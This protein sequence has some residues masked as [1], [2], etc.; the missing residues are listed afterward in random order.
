MPEGRHLGRVFVASSPLENVA[1]AL[2]RTMGM[3][4]AQGIQGQQAGLID[5]EQALRAPYLQ[6]L[7]KRY[8]EDEDFRRQVW[9]HLRGGQAQQYR[10]G[11]FDVPSAS[12]LPPG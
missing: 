8:Q 11:T 2:Q 5:R 1:T 4:Q 6:E 9:A 3:K 10:P 12:D 7:Q